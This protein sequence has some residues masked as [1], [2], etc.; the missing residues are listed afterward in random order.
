MFWVRWNKNFST[1]YQPISTNPRDD[2]DVPY[3][4]MFHVV[5]ACPA[6]VAS[7]SDL[8]RISVASPSH[9]P[10]NAH[11]VWAFP[12][13]PRR[14]IS[15]IQ[16][17]TIYLPNRINYR[18]PS[19]VDYATAYPALSCW[20]SCLSCRWNAALSPRVFGWGL[21][22]Y[23][24]NRLVTCSRVVGER[25]FCRSVPYSVPIRVN[26]SINVAICT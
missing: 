7:P 17:D 4:R 12:N 11:H 1:A 15:A 23:V 19:R 25:I 21:V 14:Y 9:L 10:R 6:S 18:E 2:R 8:R 24:I 22:K 3:W 20:M 5:V 13:H 16:C 26:R